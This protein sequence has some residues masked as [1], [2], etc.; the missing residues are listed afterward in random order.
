MAAAISTNEKRIP[1]PSRESLCSGACRALVRKDENSSGFRPLQAPRPPTTGKQ[2]DAGHQLPCF[3]QLAVLGHMAN[4]LLGSAQLLVQEAE[5][6]VAIRQARVALQRV[7][8]G[9]HRVLLAPEVLQNRG[10]VVEERRG[11]L[12]GIQRAAV[13]ALRFG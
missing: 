8:V 13:G 1:P 11:I 6:V 3:D 9:L 12:A 2:Q 5:V 4:G 10:Q 7:A